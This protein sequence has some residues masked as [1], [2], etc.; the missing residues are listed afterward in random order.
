MWV[1][2]VPRESGPLTPPP[3]AHLSSHAHLASCAG[4]MPYVA[5]SEPLGVSSLSEP[6]G[7][8][9]THDRGLHPKHMWSASQGGE[10]NG[11][12]QRESAGKRKSSTWSLFWTFLERDFPTL[13]V[14]SCEPFRHNLFTEHLWCVHHHAVWNALLSK[15]SHHISK[16][17]TLMKRNHQKIP[18][19]CSL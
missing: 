19:W 15:A 8:W 7:S 2:L 1:L 14:S 9:L 5:P 18:L 16:N 4:A 17:P 3:R 10:Q 11:E 6:T 12:G 13:C